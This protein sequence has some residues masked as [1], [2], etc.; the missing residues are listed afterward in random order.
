MR[1]RFIRSDLY[2]ILAF[3]IHG[4]MSKRSYKNNK[5]KILAPTWNEEWELLDGSYSVSDI[6]CY[7]E[8]ILKIWRKT[9]NPSIR[10]YVMKIE[11]KITFKIMAGYYVALLMPEMMK[12]IGR[13][14]GKITKNKNGE[15]EP[16][17][18]ITE[19]VLI[20]SNILKCALFRNY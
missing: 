14:K 13:T 3:T 8:Y 1:I 20:H 7:F 18:E 11:N 2:Q 16:Y 4:K 17:L 6:Q 9:D 19:E 15:N 5:F 10:M 12:L